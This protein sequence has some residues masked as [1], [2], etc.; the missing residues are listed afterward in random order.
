[1]QYSHIYKFFKTEEHAVWS[2]LIKIFIFS[3]TCFFI[4]YALNNHSVHTSGVIRQLFFKQNANDLLLLLVLMM[5]PANWG[6]EAMKWQ[7]LVRKNEK[8]SFMK[9]FQGILSGITLGFI[10]PNGIGD[11]AGRI[12]QLRGKNR[13]KNIGYLFLNR[14]AQLYITLLPGGISLIYLL[15]LKDVHP[16]IIFSCTFLIVMVNLSLF[17]LLI[18]HKFILQ[19]VQKCRIVSPVYSYFSRLGQ[20]SP[21][22]ICRIFLYSGLRY[23]VF[24]A[25][26]VLLLLYFGL[27]A[28]IPYLVMG[29]A[30]IF[31]AK[32]VLPSYFDFGVREAAAI[33]YFSGLE[34]VDQVLAASIALW[35]ILIPSF[36]GLFF[37]PRLKIFTK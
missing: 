25:Q 29:I 31:L 33:Y 35:L 7:F 20:L 13:M 36:L 16:A 37:L 3:A 18:F 27:P 6:L 17:L 23:F 5:L 32:S 9:S 4:V 30:F 1:M 34:K 28:N 11:Y 2:Q 10:T 22:E 14:L 19:T 24:S 26:F 21:G 15:I 8:M 12:L